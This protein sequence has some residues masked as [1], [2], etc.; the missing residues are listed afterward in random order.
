MKQWLLIGMAAVLLAPA[1]VQAEDPESERLRRLTDRA[2]DLEAGVGSAK[3]VAERRRLADELEQ[4]RHEM[5]AFDADGNRVHPAAMWHDAEIDSLEAAAKRLESLPALAASRDGKIHTRRMAAACLTHG[6]SIRDHWSVRRFKY[7]VDTFGQYLA[8]NLDLLD[9]LFNALPIWARKVGQLEAGSEERRAAEAFLVE[10]ANGVG[11]MGEAANR[12]ANLPKKEYGTKQKQAAL[13]GALSQFLDGMRSVRR[14]EDE[15]RQHVGGRGTSG[16]EAP[17]AEAEASPS[18]PEPPPMT[19]EEKARLEQVKAIAARLKGDEWTAVRDTLARFAEAVAVGMKVAGARPKVREFLEQ[20]EQAARLAQS[21][22]ASKAVW[23]EYRKQRL[24]ELARA[25]ALMSDPARRAEGYAR[26][27]TVWNGDHLRRQIE[28]GPTG[29]EAAQGIAYAYYRVAGRLRSA[30]GGAAATEAY[31]LETGCRKIAEVFENMTKW[32]PEG[33]PSDFRAFYEKQVPVFCKA[34]ETAG[35]HFEPGGPV[36]L[37]LMAKAAQGAQDV[38]RVIRAYRVCR[39]VSEFL[40]ARAKAMYQQL[41][42]ATSAMVSGGEG[43]SS[44][45][46]RLESMLRPFEGLEMFEVP[47]AAYQRAASRLAGRAYAPA[48]RVLNREIG[49]GIDAAS[50]GNPRTLARMLSAKSMWALLRHRAIARTLRLEPISVA[51]LVTFSLPEEKGWNRF[52]ANLDQRLLATLALYAKQG[53]KDRVPLW[54]IGA[55]D[56]VYYCVAAGQRLTRDARSEGESDLDLLFRNLERVAVSSPDGRTWKGWAVGYHA[57]EAAT[58]I[59]A[60]FEKTAEWHRGRVTRYGDSLRETDL[61][62]AP[63]TT[64]RPL[65]RD[66]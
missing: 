53:S 9:A 24:G 31:Q 65:S 42:K 7:Q 50:K 51:N 14:A 54:A 60:G 30:P 52:M 13:V 1:A 41:R 57:G 23:P 2:G 33:M 43:Q 39:Q 19:E 49:N 10:A 44:A 45:R 64:G 62:P 37:D 58:A 5:G 36:D 15:L 16:T 48:R 66:R 4:V 11:R 34:A 46:R 61:E 3:D 38:E 63:K 26:L 18:S 55:W 40:P 20:I 27:Q 29:A 21:L 56:N 8:N 17:G 22:Y 32:P 12:L 6:W 25:L 35:R 47:E 59:N 28:A